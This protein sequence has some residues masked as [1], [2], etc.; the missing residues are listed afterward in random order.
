MADWVAGIGSVAAVSATV[1]FGWKQREDLLPKLRISTTGVL[2]QLSGAPVPTFAVRFANTGS[3]PIELRGLL[4][5]SK[6]SDQALWV[7]DGMLL[8]ASDPFNTTLMPGK[9]ANIIFARS[10]LDALKGYVKHHCSGKTD[11][12]KVTASGTVKDFT[13]DV[14]PMIPKIQ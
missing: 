9:G 13:A 5:H 14:D 1:Y 10:G 8:A 2:V 12:L 4:F 7:T 11:D 3:T 6:H